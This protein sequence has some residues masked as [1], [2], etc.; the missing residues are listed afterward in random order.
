MKNILV[1]TVLVVVFASGIGIGLYKGATLK[2]S[3]KVSSDFSNGWLAAEEKLMMAGTIPSNLYSLSGEVE[4]VSGNEIYFKAD[5]KNPLLA[6]D[7]KT[8]IAVVK[9]DTSIILYKNKEQKVTP[10]QTAAAMKKR[11]EIAEARKSLHKDSPDCFKGE[12]SK[13]NSSQKCIDLMEQSEKLDDQ[14]RIINDIFTPYEVIKLKDV[15]MIVPGM[16]ISVDSR[17]FKNDVVLGENIE[18][19]SSDKMEENSPVIKKEDISKMKKFEA[20]SIELREVLK[21]V[22]KPAQL[23]KDS[24]VVEV[25]PGQFEVIK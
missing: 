20:G 2:T 18:I 21:Q 12:V 8:R 22:D 10:E 13:E 11:M 17:S 25:A 19:K 7:L 6:E 3:G 15:S 14:E 5:L 4:K 24:G 16:Q 23:E 9:N 1:V